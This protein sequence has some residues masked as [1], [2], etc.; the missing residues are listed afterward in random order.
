[1]CNVYAGG[2]LP[3]MVNNCNA[4][5]WPGIVGGAGH[6]KLIKG[7]FRLGLGEEVTVNLPDAWSSS[8]GPAGLLLR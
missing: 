3:V 1:M 8:L 7:G 4:T 6:P 5:A 2:T